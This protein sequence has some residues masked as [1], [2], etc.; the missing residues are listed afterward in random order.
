MKGGRGLK[1]SIR[2]EETTRW[3]DYTPQRAR[4]DERRPEC[5][6]GREDYLRKEDGERGG[7]E[8]INTIAGGFAGRGSSN[9]TRKKHLRAV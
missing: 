9:N 2:R 7:R 3:R 1:R 4:E 6:S 8:V 5:R